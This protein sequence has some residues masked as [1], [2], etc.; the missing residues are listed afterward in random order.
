MGFEGAVCRVCTSA[1]FDPDGATNRPL[2]NEHHKGPPRRTTLIALAHELLL[3][4]WCEVVGFAIAA[5]LRALLIVFFGAGGLF[6]VNLRQRW[7]VTSSDSQVFPK[8]APVSQAGRR[9]QKRGLWGA[10]RNADGVI[11]L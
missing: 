3:L 1:P 5:S 4:L 9:V 2:A 10:Y 7:G 11:I 6:W 8:T